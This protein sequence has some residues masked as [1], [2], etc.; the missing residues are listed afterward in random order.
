MAPYAGYRDAA[1]PSAQS[2]FTSASSESTGSPHGDGDHE[3][4][5]RRCQAAMAF[6]RLS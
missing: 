3:L 6:T 1:P 5:G 2:S 4:L